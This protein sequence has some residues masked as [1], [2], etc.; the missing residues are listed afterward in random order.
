MQTSRLKGV[1]F[2][3]RRYSE[4]DRSKE[5]GGNTTIGPHQL[6]LEQDEFLYEECIQPS[7]ALPSRPS[8]SLP[9]HATTHSSKRPQHSA[10]SFF[11][12]TLLAATTTHK[13]PHKSFSGVGDAI[14]EFRSHPTRVMSRRKRNNFSI[15]QSLGEE[16]EEYNHKYFES[17]PAYAVSEDNPAHPQGSGWLRRR[18]PSTIGHAHPPASSTFT[19]SPPQLPMV[20]SYSYDDEN[21]TALPAFPGD[22]GELPR[23]PEKIVSGAA[24]RAAAAAQNEIIDSMRNIRLAEPKVTRDSESGVGIEVRDQ[25]ELAKNLDVPYIRQG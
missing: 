24:A 1:L 20:P 2:K 17:C 14:V 16:S 22:E 6:C 8:T 21:F 5:S 12:E 9:R 10:T 11:E 15:D 4:A 25:G 23:P 3:R 7:N 18:L 13:R 19:S